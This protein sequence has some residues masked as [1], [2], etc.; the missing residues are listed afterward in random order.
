MVFC[1]LF[2]KHLTTVNYLSRLT[3]LRGRTGILFCPGPGG[4]RRSREVEYQWLPKSRGEEIRLHL[5]ELR[6][7]YY[8]G[9]PAG[10]SGQDFSCGFLNQRRE[11]K[12]NFCHLTMITAITH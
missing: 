11:S 2:S 4:R 9:N 1:T 12:G 8:G 10:K 7:L 3:P 6:G 5:S